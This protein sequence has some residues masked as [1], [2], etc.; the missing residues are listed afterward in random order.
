M[1]R[2]GASVTSRFLTTGSQNSGEDENN[3]RDGSLPAI[4]EDFK[5]NSVIT[6]GS[7][8]LESDYTKTRDTSRLAKTT[9]RKDKSTMERRK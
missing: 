3:L 4:G 2:S 7:L 8:D 1:D 9:I 5:M 6:K